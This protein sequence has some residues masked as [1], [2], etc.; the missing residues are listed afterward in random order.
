M[1]ALSEFF[2]H[3]YTMTIIF[4]SLLLLEIV[5]LIRT[6][7]GNLCSARQRLVT[8]NQFLKSIEEKNPTISYKKINYNNNN[9]NKVECAVCLSDFED[10]E[11][12]RR[13][14]CQHTFHKDCLD[15]WLQQYLATCPLCRTKVL[16][17][18]VVAN[19]HLQLQNNNQVEYY[20]GSD[21][22]MIFLLS[23]L[24]GNSLHR[25]F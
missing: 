21:E 8:T 5:I 1:G 17:D 13:L 4:V 2:S 10:G 15:R 22:E 14:K 11:K 3:V 20:D 23:A 16:P 9:N 7:T 6:V 12:V 18:A 19:F 25:F 24:H